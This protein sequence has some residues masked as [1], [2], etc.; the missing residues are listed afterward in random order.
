MGRCHFGKKKKRKMGKKKKE[1]VKETGENTNHKGK[2]E[3]NNKIILMPKG[4]K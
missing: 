3:V 1:N 2:N 4:Q